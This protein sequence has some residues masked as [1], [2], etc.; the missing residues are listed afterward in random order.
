M[1]KPVVAQ[2]YLTSGSAVTPQFAWMLIA[3]AYAVAGVYSLAP[4]PLCLHAY[5]ELIFKD[6]F[7]FQ[8]LNP[9]LRLTVSCS[10]WFLS[11]VRSV[12]KS[13]SAFI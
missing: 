5:F 2:Q 3:P 11:L 6:R 12:G 1:V 8:Q 9:G 10:L 7:P 4:F 13:K